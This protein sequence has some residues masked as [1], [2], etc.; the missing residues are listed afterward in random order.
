MG[1]RDLT[2]GIKYSKQF[3]VMLA[4]LSKVT[5]NHYTVFL[6]SVNFMNI[7]CNSESS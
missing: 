3:I 5:K 4:P 1:I 6:K 2:V 7:K